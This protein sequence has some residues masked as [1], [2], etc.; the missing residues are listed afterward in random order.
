MDMICYMNHCSVAAKTPMNSG[1]DL[2]QIPS[3]GQ[4]ID[5]LVI[6]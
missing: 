1:I 4:Y 2:K 3:C 5:I 6:L